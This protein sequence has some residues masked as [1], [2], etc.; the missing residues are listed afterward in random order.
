MD[1]KYLIHFG[2]NTF[3]ASEYQIK[4]FQCIEYGVGNM[5]I[6]ASAG[7]SKTTS[8]VNGINYIPK[9]K[10]VLFV[11]FNKDIASKIKTLVERENTN[12]HTFHSLRYLHLP[13][14]QP[15]LRKMALHHRT[16]YRT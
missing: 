12:V 5:V 1:K 9:E 7:S 8:I 2:D 4:I 13:P 3:E 10:R 6:N 15:W 14:Q 11:A 16:Q